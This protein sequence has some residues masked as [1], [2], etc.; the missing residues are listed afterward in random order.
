VWDLA[1]CAIKKLQRGDYKYRSSDD[2]IL[3]ARWNDNSNITVASTLHTV[4][5]VGIMKRYWKIEKKQ[6]TILHPL[7]IVK[8]NKFMDGTDLMD[9]NVNRYIIGICSKN[10][11]GQ[12]SCCCWMY[13]SRIYGI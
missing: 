8:Y 5:P 11:C 9:E 7:L 6:T 13:Q 4:S 3:C 1:S 12:F 10:G 2:C